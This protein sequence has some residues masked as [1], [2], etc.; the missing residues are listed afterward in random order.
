MY[1][2]VYQ[3]YTLVL[4]MSIFGHCSTPI[5]LRNQWLAL[6]IRPLRVPSYSSTQSIKGNISNVSAIEL[7][8]QGLSQTRHALCLKLLDS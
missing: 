2:Y 3:K 1:T 6:K 8:L 4:C 7:I 5:L